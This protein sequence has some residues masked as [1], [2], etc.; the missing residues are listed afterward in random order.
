MSQAPTDYLALA[1]D[2]LADA[3]EAIRKELQAVREWQ[4][5]HD[6]VSEER[7]IRFRGPIQTFWRIMAA[8]A[9]GVGAVILKFIADHLEFRSPK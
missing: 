1:V 2:R 5:R 4:A 6:A 8:F 3:V 7:V 9:I